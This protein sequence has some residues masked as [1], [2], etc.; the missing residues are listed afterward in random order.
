MSSRQDISPPLCL[1]PCGSAL[2]IRRTLREPGHLTVRSRTKAQKHSQSGSLR[3]PLDWLQSELWVHSHRAKWGLQ[4][5][6]SCGQMAEVFADNH[7][8]LSIKRRVSAEICRSENHPRR[9][10]KDVIEIMDNSVQWLTAHW[11]LALPMFL[12]AL[13]IGLLMPKGE[14]RSKLIGSLVGLAALGLIGGTLLRP[15]GALVQDTL[16][17]L[18]SGVAVISATLMITNRNPAYSA[19]WFAL[20]TLSVCGLFL[21][22]SAPFL[23]SATVIVYAGAIIV[24]FL[25]V[26]MLAQQAG[27]TNYDQNARQ[28]GIIAFTGFVLLGALLFVITPPQATAGKLAMNDEPKTGFVSLAPRPIEIAKKS[29]PDEQLAQVPSSLRGVMPP[30]IPS[31]PVE[32]AKPPQSTSGS[33][34]ENFGT[35]R[36]LGRSLF[37]DYLFA[38]ELAGTLLLVAS[39]GAIIIAPKRSSGKF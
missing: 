17:F 6:P 10:T 7:G 27:T 21:L 38:V 19:L 18:F 8:F 25:F 36:G 12:G 16:F 37:G 11:Q 26:L 2:G 30:S 23:A 34:P 13:A 14:R 9:Q 29:K 22:Q 3:H 33:T 20:V 31:T 28:P 32:A 15:S 35:M 4:Y 39:I 5:P 1:H 24:T